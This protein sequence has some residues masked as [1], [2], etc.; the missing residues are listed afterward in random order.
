MWLPGL[1]RRADHPYDVCRQGRGDGRTLSNRT[2]PYV[3]AHRNAGVEE[4]AN[5]ID[6]FTG[7][8]L[9]S[10]GTSMLEIIADAGSWNVSTG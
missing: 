5:E 2:K 4:L 6:D 3:R 1:S 9:L 7:Q 8:V 10:G